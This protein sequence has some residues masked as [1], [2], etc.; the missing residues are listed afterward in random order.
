MERKH[1]TKTQCQISKVKVDAAATKNI[2]DSAR[3]Q[4]QHKA[5]QGGRN[6]VDRRSSRTT[7]TVEKRRP[8]EAEKE[9]SDWAEDPDYKNRDRACDIC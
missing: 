2:P 1:R 6:N 7:G 5:Y 4:M 3:W 8:E 9:I